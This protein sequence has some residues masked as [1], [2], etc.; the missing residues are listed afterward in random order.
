M[1]YSMKIVLLWDGA[2]CFGAE[3]PKDQLKD[4]T[5]WK[6]KMQCPV[7]VASFAGKKKSYNVTPYDS[8]KNIL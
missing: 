7:Y 8:V 2:R 3:L 5:S 4:K 1:L 6:S